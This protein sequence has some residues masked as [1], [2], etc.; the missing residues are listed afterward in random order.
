MS[1][2]LEAFNFNIIFVNKVLTINKLKNFFSKNE[3]YRYL[4]S[5]EKNY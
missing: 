1:T 2:L 5:E 4:L 3:I